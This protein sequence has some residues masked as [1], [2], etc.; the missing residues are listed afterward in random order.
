MEAG[1]YYYLY[2]CL[3]L[4]PYLAYDY[5][6][7]AG[8]GIVFG[9]GGINRGGIGAQVRQVYGGDLPGLQSI[10][11]AV[12]PGGVLHII[13][14]ATYYSRCSPPYVLIKGGRVEVGGGGW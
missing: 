4:I 2:T 3:Q 1:F 10:V 7:G 12:L 5:T 13:Y 9:V 8:V 11:Y 6:H 14:L